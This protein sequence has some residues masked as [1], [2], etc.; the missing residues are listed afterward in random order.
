VLAFF[1]CGFF[2]AFIDV[3]LVANLHDHGVGPTVSSVTFVALAALEVVGAVV[4][5]R[6]C[7]AGP[8]N[9]VLV[10]RLSVSHGVVRLAVL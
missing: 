6:L 9:R 7:D 4:A 1:C 2:M 8:A 5:G 10:Q 3:Y